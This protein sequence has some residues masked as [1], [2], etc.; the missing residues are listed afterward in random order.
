MPVPLAWVMQMKLF[1]FQDLEHLYASQENLYI[2]Q[3]FTDQSSRI[4]WFGSNLDGKN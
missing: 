3:I 4:E 2:T 1:A